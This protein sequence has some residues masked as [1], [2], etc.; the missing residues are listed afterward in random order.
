MKLFRVVWYDVL[1]VLSKFRVS[2][3]QFHVWLYK[4]FVK[5]FLERAQRM[6]LKFGRMIWN[7]VQYILSDFQTYPTLTSC[8]CVVICGPWTVFLH[9]KAFGSL[10]WEME[11]WRVIANFFKIFYKFEP[12]IWRN[13]YQHMVCFEE[14]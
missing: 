3:T 11:L 12:C 8:F 1:Y 2:W 9:V 13:M 7:D 10:I 4:I 6:G 14:V 5:F